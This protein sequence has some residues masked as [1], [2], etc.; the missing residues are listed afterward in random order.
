MI[1]T[2]ANR[3]YSFKLGIWHSYQT[4]FK[5]SSLLLNNPTQASFSSSADKTHDYLIQI[6]TEI[7]NKKNGVAETAAAAAAVLLSSPS[8]PHSPSLIEYANSYYLFQH[9]NRTEIDKEE[10]ERKKERKKKG[11]KERN[12]KER[13]FGKCAVIAAPLLFLIA[14][15]EAISKPN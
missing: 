2:T 3:M 8:W 13:T 15:T 10:K 14:T 11:R 12:K 1:L 9:P 4:C 5:F 7:W 6:H